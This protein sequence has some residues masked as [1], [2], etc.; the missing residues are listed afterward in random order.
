MDVVF[1]ADR[2]VLPGLHVAAYS[3]LERMSPA[4]GMVRFTIFSDALT[5]ADIALLEKTLKQLG[6][7]FTLAL[8]RVDASFFTKF[9]SLNGSWA[10]YYRL[11]AAQAM[12]TDRF[13]YV[14]A[15]TLCDVDMSPLQSLDMGC[16]PAAWVPEAPLVHAVD[17]VVAEQL[18]N[19]PDEYYFNAGIM[20]INVV[21][22]QKQQITEK[23]MAYLAA[24][25]PA[26]WDQSALNNV[27]YRNAFVLDGK[28]NCIA[29]M[30]KNWPALTLPYG[31]IG[32]LIHFLDYPK[33]WDWVGELVHPQYRLWRSVLDKTAMKGFRSWRPAPSRKFPVTVKARTGYKKNIKDRILF[34]GYS[35]G[36][37]KSVKGV[38]KT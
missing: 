15:D 25:R 12:S 10:T 11:F 14:D 30:R 9:P 29:N 3:L 6:R 19:S 33:P 18:G 7:P 31:K 20:L 35:K 23:A 17:R 38:P 22:W 37:L 4:A 27:L 36:W 21:E 32:K 13:L 26:F 8:R 2:S 5:E 1:C 34:S 16:F 28:F 24:N